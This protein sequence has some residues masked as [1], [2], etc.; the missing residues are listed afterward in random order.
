MS[1]PRP[2]ALLTAVHGSAALLATGCLLGM[3]GTGLVDRGTALAFGARPA[4]EL[5]EGDES[6]EG[7]G[8][9]A[10]D[11]AAPEHAEQ[12]TRGEE[13]GAAADDGEQ[14]RWPRA[15]HRGAPGA[16]AACG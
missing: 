8:G 16:P 9:P 4:G 14:G 13:G 1:G 5:T 12:A 2:P 10:V 7:E 6:P 3:L 11:E 15:A